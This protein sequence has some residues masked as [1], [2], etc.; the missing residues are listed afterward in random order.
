MNDHYPTPK[1][2]A[3]RPAG[4]DEA[5]PAR[6][7]LIEDRRDQVVRKLEDAWQAALDDLFAEPRA[8]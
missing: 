6:L 1:Q 4:P 5:A 7:A 8:A 3:A 2:D